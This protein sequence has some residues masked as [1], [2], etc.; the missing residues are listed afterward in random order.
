MNSSRRSNPIS[1]ACNRPTT[2]KEKSGTEIDLFLLIRELACRFDRGN[3]RANHRAYPRKCA[4]IIVRRLKLLLKALEVIHLC[5]S[6]VEKMIISL[7]G[8]C[9]RQLY[10]ERRLPQIAPSANSANHRIQTY[11]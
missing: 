2:I 8:E 11:L 5:G 7:I 6:P 3:G 9:L 1:L 4:P 10:P